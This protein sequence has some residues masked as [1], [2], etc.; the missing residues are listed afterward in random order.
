MPTLS[1]THMLRFCILLFIAALTAFPSSSAFCGTHV[2]LLSAMLFVL[3]AMLFSATFRSSSD[4][5]VW[6]LYSFRLLC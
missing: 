2:A 6:M 3:D 5:V 1:R 4:D